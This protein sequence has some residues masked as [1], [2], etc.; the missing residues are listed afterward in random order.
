MDWAQILVII[1]AIFLGLLV[2]SGVVLV[3][4][5]IRLTHQIKDVANNAE[6]AAKNIE[7]AVHSFSQTTSP[8]VAV[9][10]IIKRLKKRKK[11]QGEE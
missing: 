2:L 10:M 5:F 6:R 8:L 9:R 4:V 1:L 7:N 11:N 3:I